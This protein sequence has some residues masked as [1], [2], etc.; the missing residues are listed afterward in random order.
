[1]RSQS[2]GTSPKVPL[3]DGSSPSDAPGKPSSA[4]PAAT[5]EHLPYRTDG[6]GPVERLAGDTRQAAAMGVA[7]GSRPVGA[8]PPVAP[9]GDGGGAQA[10]PSA[11]Q[12]ETARV[13]VG[14]AVGPLTAE[15]LEATREWLAAADDSHFSIQLL[16]TD[17]AS[18]D[19]LESFLRERRDAGEVNHYYVFETRIRSNIWYGVLYME[20]T[21]F[22]AAKAAL[23]ELPEEFRFHQP[24]IRN[25]RDIATLG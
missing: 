4:T 25:V 5:L 8:A 16:L 1:M 15:R 20:Y 13:P 17:F 23:E 6:D 7:G 14:E 19:N 10:E 11:V 9:A 21:S 18:R 22:G 24:F 3:A 12:A 2:A